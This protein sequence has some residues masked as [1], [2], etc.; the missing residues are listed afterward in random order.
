[1]GAEP[2]IEVKGLWC[3]LANGVKSVTVIGLDGCVPVP[4]GPANNVTSVV[5]A[6]AR[7]CIV[8]GIAYTSLALESDNMKTAS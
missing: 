6:Y 1:M 2:L 8:I 5:P 4:L 3:C 7:N